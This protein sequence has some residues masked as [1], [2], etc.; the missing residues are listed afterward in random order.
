MMKNERQAFLSEHDTDDIA[1]AKKFLT[2]HGYF[3]DKND[4]VA[5]VEMDN[6]I[7]AVERC[8]RELKEVVINGKED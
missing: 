7:R 5:N 8:F 3:A 1:K 2:K 4:V 6:A